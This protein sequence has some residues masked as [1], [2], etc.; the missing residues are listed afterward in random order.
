MDN[1]NRIVLRFVFV[2]SILLLAFVCVIAKAVYIQTVERSEW[3][4]LAKTL[5]RRDKEIAPERGNIY[6]YDGKLIS[7][8]IPYYTLLM[9]TRVPALHN[10]AGKLFKENID[11]L[12]GA[13][14][15]YF[16]DRTKDEYKKHI[17]DGY[18]A[19]KGMLRLYPKK[20]SYVDLVNVK[21]FPLIEKG[22]NTSGFIPRELVSRENLYGS[23][24]S[25]TIGNV[26]GSGKGGAYGLEK[27]YDKELTGKPGMARGLKVGNGWVYE[28]ME[29][30]VQG[31]DLITTIDIGLQDIC[32]KTLR[33]MLVKTDAERGCLLLMDVE[34]GAMRASVNLQKVDSAEYREIYN[35]GVGDLSEPGSTFKLVSLMVALEDGKCDLEKEV[36]TYDGEFKF[37]GVSMTDHNRKRGGYQ[38]ITLA[39]AI[40]YSSNI[41]ISRVIHDA[42]HSDPG[43]FVDAIKATKIVDDMHIEIPGAAVPV[44]DHPDSS[45]SWSGTS[46][47]WM[48]IGYVVQM[49][50]I[51]TLAFYNAI[52]NGGKLMKPYFVSAISS[53]GKVVEQ[54][55]PTVINPS[56]CSSSTLRDMKQVLNGVIE[57]GT[58]KNVNSEYVKIAGKTGTAQINYG[59]AGVR[60]SHQ[61][62]FCGYFPADNPKYTAIVVIRQPRRGY[63]SGSIMAGGV[64]KN[65]AE[66][67][68]AHEVYLSVNDVELEE[69][70]VA[71]PEVMNGNRKYAENALDYIGYDAE[72]GETEWVKID[73]DDNVGEYM[74]ENIP[75]MDNYV[76]D[77]RGMSAQDAVYLIERCGMAVQLYG[78]GKVVRQ[79]VKPQTEVQRGK[80]VTLILK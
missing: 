23:L 44:L 68:N 42:Y 48:S 64:F 54:F 9:D 8:T 21:K 31:N 3:M 16:G 79:T 52:A 33:D 66:R 50:P 80:T 70:S 69:D 18:L 75:S 32:D 46:L 37:Y 20:V 5:E 43:K 51:Y 4:E 7:A 27:Y 60:M 36:E 59:K 49:P 11:T 41:G 15:A 74:W 61:V 26:F 17:N 57:Y 29:E 1:K 13:F 55:E 24:C 77:V 12:A 62:S 56:I 53:Q 71:L 76:P 39:E 40:A 10:N 19:G 22:R 28:M 25:R 73:V 72:F 47:P 6:T 58:G 35:M 14:A 45:D 30:P 38:T 2:Y 78:R 65:M 63:A 34:T 67:V